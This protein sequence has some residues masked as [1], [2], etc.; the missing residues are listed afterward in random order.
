MNW[1]HQLGIRTR[2]LLLVLVLA[3]PF[4][5]YV[6]ITA[7]RQ[8]QSEREA[9]G[10]L[11]MSAA[12]VTAAR[13]DDHVGDIEQVL[14][15]VSH[16]IGVTA[17]DTAANNK[18]LG[19]IATS[20][21]AHINN[22]AVWTPGGDNIGMLHP[23]PVQ[24]PIEVKDIGWFK[25][26]LRGDGVAV[27]APR[28][29]PVNG[30]YVAL[31]ARAIRRNGE[32]VGVLTASTRLHRLQ[33]LLAPAATLPDAALVSVVNPAGKLIARSA[34]AERWVGADLTKLSLVAEGRQR[35]EGVAEGPG[36]D[37]V[38]LLSGFTTASR[39]P[40]LVYV[41]SPLDTVLADVRRTTR[42][43][44]LVG[45][46]MLFVGLALAGWVGGRVS[47]PLRQLSA[48]AATIGSGELAHRSTVR[49]GGETGFLA[50]TLN[51]MAATLQDRS[52]SLE[53]S[54][55]QLRQ[56]TDNLPAMI[57]Y[58]DADQRFRFANRAHLDW[59]GIEPKDLIGISLRE[60]YGDVA[61]A[62]FAHHINTAL[63]GERVVYERELETP[64]GA[65]HVQSTVVP[66]IGPNGQVQGLYVL[67]HDITQRKLN[68][69]RLRHM[70]EFDLLTG[71]PNR[72]LFTDRLQQ[73]MARA[74]RTHKPMALLFIDVDHFKHINDE[75][76]HPVGDELLKSF[77]RRLQHAVRTSDTVARLSGDEF[78]VIL[79]HLNGMDDARRLTAKISDAIRVPMVVLGHEI[80]VTA[81]IGV[82]LCA[83]GDADGTGLLRRADAALYEAKRRGRDGYFCE[84]DEE[85]RLTAR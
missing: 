52:V 43:N 10:L 24:S 65:M 20:L 14:G 16:V 8:A 37:G 49:E 18:M 62:G 84:G 73:A 71:L 55:E 77:S 32:V 76:G 5:G 81:S 21:P 9:A 68:E 82:A 28:V 36:A 1:P 51:E 22:I 45:G 53:R 79:H 44:L 80:K 26:A 69:E 46:A 75:F 47:R 61:Y 57:A 54:Q 58:L 15:V 63:S 85:T 3:L 40:W 41:S 48:D 23:A 72:G 31:F 33:N 17:A 2:L 38:V 13:L 27:D 6:A 64:T 66:Q 11:M 4:L 39:V 56:I 42:D 59:L 70:A 30:Q 78:T 83:P 67:M 19:T 60:Q 34:D 7:V 50:R 25:E 35:R 74:G 29:S 12:R